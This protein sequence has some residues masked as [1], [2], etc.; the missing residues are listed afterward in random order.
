VGWLLVRPLF[1][2][3][4]QISLNRFAKQVSENLGLDPA[5]GA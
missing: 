1:A 3:G 2:Y 5:P 4:V